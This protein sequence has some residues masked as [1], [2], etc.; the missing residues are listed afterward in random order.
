M[1]SMRRLTPDTTDQQKRPSILDPHGQSSHDYSGGV[2]MTRR[3]AD[4]SFG[5]S[6]FTVDV[7]MEIPGLP[8]RRLRR[9]TVFYDNRERTRGHLRDGR[10]VEKRGEGKNASWWYV[11][12]G[13]R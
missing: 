11:A 9:Q 7:F 13:R 2:D 12:G 1:V 10:E 5:K 6:P 3:E 8:G 4:W